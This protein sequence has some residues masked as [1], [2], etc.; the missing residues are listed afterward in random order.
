MNDDED[1]GPFNFAFGEGAAEEF[2]ERLKEVMRAQKEAFDEL[3]A[4]A[5]GQVAPVDRWQVVSR[6]VDLAAAGLRTLEPR[7]TPDDAADAMGMMF[8]RA[9]A[10]LQGAITPSP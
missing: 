7:S 2:K 3:Q 6:A 1:F 9:L 10:A 8:A 5:G 4:E